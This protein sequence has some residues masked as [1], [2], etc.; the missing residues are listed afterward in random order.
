M[1]LDR[2]KILNWFA[3]KTGPGHVVVTRDAELVRLSLQKG[4]SVLSPEGHVQNIEN[5]ESQLVADRLLRDLESFGAAT[6]GALPLNIRDRSRFTMVLRET[7]LPLQE[8]RKSEEGK[9]DLPF[10]DE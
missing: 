8:A 6:G 7:V 3:E 10:R 1:G 9:E 4:A 5:L 2:Q